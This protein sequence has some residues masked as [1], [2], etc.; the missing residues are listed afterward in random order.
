MTLPTRPLG[1]SGLEITPVGFGAWAIGGGGCIGAGAGPVR[2]ERAAA[3]GRAR[4]RPDTMRDGAR[5]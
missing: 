3:P 5:R 4:N 2:P 1:T